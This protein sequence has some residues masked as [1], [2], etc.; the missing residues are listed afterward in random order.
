MCSGLWMGQSLLG[1]AAIS[2][3]VRCKLSIALQDDSCCHGRMASYSDMRGF[4]TD[5]NN[6]AA[7]Q[8]QQVTSTCSVMWII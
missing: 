2:K 4:K 3:S 1:F 8:I 7:C 5:S 6:A